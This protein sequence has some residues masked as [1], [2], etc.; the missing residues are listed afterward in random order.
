VLAR[1]NKIFSITVQDI[2]ILLGRSVDTSFQT[3]HHR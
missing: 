2:E 1:F 3:T